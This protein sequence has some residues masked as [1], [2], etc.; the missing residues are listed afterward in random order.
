MIKSALLTLH[1]VS[2]QYRMPISLKT[3]YCLEEK[4]PVEGDSAL[5]KWQKKEI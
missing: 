5:L 1:F 4:G 3:K 2:K